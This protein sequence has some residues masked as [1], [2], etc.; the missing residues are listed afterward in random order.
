MD[1]NSLDE[2]F[3]YVRG[4]LGYEYDMMFILYMLK[5]N[6]GLMGG[7]MKEWSVKWNDGKPKGQR[8]NGIFLFGLGREYASC[9]VYINTFIRAL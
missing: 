7:G 8:S 3:F 4:W 2:F 9:I 1:W 6:D 5:V